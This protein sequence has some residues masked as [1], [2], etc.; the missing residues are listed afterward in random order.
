[1]LAG[2]WLK[3]VCRFAWRIMHVP[4][5]SKCIERQSNIVEILNNNHVNFEVYKVC[6]TAEWL[7]LRMPLGV[8]LIEK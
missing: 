8:L 7:L 2:T 3:L 5:M 4:M 1:V 6:T